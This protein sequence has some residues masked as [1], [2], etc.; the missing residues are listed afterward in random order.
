MHIAD[1]ISISVPTA[2]ELC[3]IVP[4]IQHIFVRGNITQRCVRPEGKET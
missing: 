3:K 2:Y 4:L 1:C